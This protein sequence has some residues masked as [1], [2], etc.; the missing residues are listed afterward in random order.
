MSKMLDRDSIRH[1]LLPA[2][3]TIVRFLLLVIFLVSIFPWLYEIK[4]RVGIDVFP[5]T[6][7]GTVVEEYTH[8]LVKCEWL[9]PYHCSERAGS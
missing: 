6:H 2:G 1:N 7:T 5:G 9:Y 8:N 4:S 3:L